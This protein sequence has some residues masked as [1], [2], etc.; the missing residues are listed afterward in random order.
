MGQ[1]RGRFGRKTGATVRRTIWRDQMLLQ[2]VCV[3]QKKVEYNVQGAHRNKFFE[4]KKEVLA[5]FKRQ[6]DDGGLEVGFVSSYDYHPFY[7]LNKCKRWELPNLLKDN[8]LFD[9]L[10][11]T[12]EFEVV[13][14]EYSMGRPVTNL[15]ECIGIHK[16]K[17]EVHCKQ[18]RDKY[19]HPDDLINV[20]QNAKVSNANRNSGNRKKRRK[21][22]EDIELKTPTPCIKYEVTYARPRE[23]Y[24]YFTSRH[25]YGYT[26]GSSKGKSTK[27]QRCNKYLF[28]FEEDD[29]DFYSDHFD[30]DDG[31]IGDE[32]SMVYVYDPEFSIG[33]PPLLSLKDHLKFSDTP[34]RSQKKNKSQK[35]RKMCTTC[36]EIKISGKDRKITI[37][38]PDVPTT[39]I[40]SSL[41]NTMAVSPDSLPKMP[42]STSVLITKSSVMPKCLETI[43]K[44]DYIE[45]ASLPR[46]FV[47]DLTSHVCDN[48]HKQGMSKGA[49]NLGKM[50]RRIVVNFTKVQ[51][52]LSESLVNDAWREKNGVLL[53]EVDNFRVCIFGLQFISKYKHELTNALSN[54]KTFSVTDVISKIKTILDQLPAN[55]FYVDVKT[56]KGAS[57]HL[58]FKSLQQHLKQVSEVT[59]PHALL[60]QMITTNE[61]TEILNS[62]IVQ[63]KSCGICFEELLPS[64]GGCS[65]TALGSCQH[66][67]CDYCWRHHIHTRIGRGDCSILCP[68][69]RCDSKVDTPTLMSLTSNSQ[70][71]NHFNHKQNRIVDNDPSWHWCPEPGCRHVGKVRQCKDSHGFVPCDCGKAWCVR[72]KEDVHWPASCQQAEEYK[73]VI[74]KREDYKYISSVQVKRCPHCHRHFEKNGGCP[75]MECICGKIFCWVCLEPHYFSPECYNKKI[76]FEHVKTIKKNSYRKNSIKY[77]LLPTKKRICSCGS[78]EEQRQIHTEAVAM[79]EE[80]AEFYTETCHLLEWMCVLVAYSVVSHSKKM[81][82]ISHLLPKLLC[83]LETLDEI[84]SKKRTIC[85]NAKNTFR[86]LLTSGKRRR[87]ILCNNASNA[88][89]EEEEKVMKERN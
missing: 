8:I 54:S 12:N 63:Q 33:P 71:Q 87:Q 76:S 32:E 83:I 28:E 47:I 56:S 23:Q 26:E 29:D 35:K 59:T 64:I 53:E 48:L 52:D 62:K 75:N 77:D 69:Y 46:R 1:K 20:E 57:S 79:A 45:G 61:T 13:L 5:E 72:C 36:D 14:V 81:K 80:V 30:S 10:H 85:A 39:T 55:Y 22:S 4:K 27:K 15:S 3:I 78:T 66:W 88:R 70:F 82:G 42:P 19:A 31:N 49:T 68:E 84:I 67:F 73:N 34:T 18:P 41:A 44:R 86:Q 89:I 58:A 74:R 9:P 50:G 40:I 16:S 24:P 2:E 25:L 37:P 11:E 51:K 6:F 60:L 7:S 65:G 17:G 21:K 43:F 38:S